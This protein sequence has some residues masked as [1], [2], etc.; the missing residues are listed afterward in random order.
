M[1]Q[2]G[3]A[4]RASHG[5]RNSH[6]LDMG[7]SGP[8]PV[9]DV[10][11]IGAGVVGAALAPRL[12]LDGYR[13]VVLEGAA[14]V[15]D[16]ASKGTSG[17]L[18][19][20]F[21]APPGTLEAR[22][23]A[24][25]RAEFLA[26]REALNLPLLETGAMALA[27]NEA[28]ALPLLLEQA[29]E[30]GVGDAALSSAAAIRELEP[31]LCSGLRGG[32]RVPGEHVINRWSTRP[33]GGEDDLPRAPTVF[34]RSGCATRLFGSLYFTYSSCVNGNLGSPLNIANGGKSVAPR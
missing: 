33:R 12:Q 1:R 17:I 6:G 24:A 19:T 10:A 20:R 9:F 5:N 4:R 25:G 34:S 30:N 2:R 23:V 18:H 15:L 16:G 29:H 32:M 27:W 3:T 26:I 13:V 28:A 11:V 22:C 8:G 7:Q 21:D 14:E 31:E